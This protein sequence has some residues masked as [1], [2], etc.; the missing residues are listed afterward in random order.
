M[1]CVIETLD[2]NADDAN[3]YVIH[4]LFIASDPSVC[5]CVARSLSNAIHGSYPA[6]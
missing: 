4:S 5:Q 1:F 2:T 3:L 6:E